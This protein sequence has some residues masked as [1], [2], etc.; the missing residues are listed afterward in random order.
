ML[1]TRK[2]KRSFQWLTKGFAGKKILTSK[3]MFILFTDYYEKIAQQ[4]PMKG[5]SQY[6]VLHF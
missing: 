5:G 1:A 4:L 2:H 6:Q 3:R